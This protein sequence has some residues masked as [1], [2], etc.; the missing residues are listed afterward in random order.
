VNAWTIVALLLALAVGAY[1]VWALL[2][3]ED[4]Q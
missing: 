1:L 3:A 2:C 4:F